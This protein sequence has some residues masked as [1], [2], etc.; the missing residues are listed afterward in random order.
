[1][2]GSRLGR[3]VVIDPEAVSLTALR[4]FD[5]GGYDTVSMDDV[6]LAAGVSRRSLFRL[7]PTKASL[8]WGGF[9]EFAARLQDALERTPHDASTRD[10][11]RTAYRAAA[12]FPL[13]AIEVTRRRLRVIVANPELAGDGVVRSVPL[14]AV[15][16]DFIARRHHGAD[17]ADGF[18]SVVVAQALAAAA[19]SA[20]AWWALHSD[21]RPEDV[22]ER[23]IEL[24]LRPLLGAPS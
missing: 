6:A 9:E 12:T 19:S 17:G 11:L 22:T 7:F 16:T 2:A 24:V 15:V 10:A 21:E 1:M 23:A 5:E 18:E 20:L 8:L 14:N 13:S 4:L 3:P